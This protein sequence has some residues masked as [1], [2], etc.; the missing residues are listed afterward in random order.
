MAWATPDG[1]TGVASR[2]N[3]LLGCGWFVVTTSVMPGV[4]ACSTANVH[5][6]QASAWE[7][8]GRPRSRHR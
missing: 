6:D 2:P 4:S 8:V 3:Q 5:G 1:S 7:Y